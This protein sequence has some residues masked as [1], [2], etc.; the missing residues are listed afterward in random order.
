MKKYFYVWNSSDEVGRQP[1]SSFRILSS[2]L[3]NFS[4]QIHFPQVIIYPYLF[5][6][7]NFSYFINYQ[8]LNTNGNKRKCLSLKCELYIW[9]HYLTRDVTWRL[10]NAK[11]S[12]YWFLFFF[13]SNILN[14]FSKKCTIII[15]I[16]PV[17]Y[18]Y[19]VVCKKCKTIKKL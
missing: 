7:E 10:L 6:L 4:R 1:N 9:E 19:R 3:I 2:F 11:N 14:C 17:H 12:T 8:W 5:L 16:Q 18:T 15:F 13:S